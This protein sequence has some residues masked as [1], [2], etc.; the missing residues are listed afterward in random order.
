MNR[1]RF[2]HI[3]RFRHRARPI[4]LMVALL[5]AQYVLIAHQIEHQLR[6]TDAS[7]DICLTAQHLSNT[8]ISKGIP[9]AIVRGQDGITFS[10]VVSPLSSRIITGFSA[11]APPPFLHV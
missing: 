10:S 11:R 1:L 8:P 6:A 4:L 9:P 2:L 3:S 5:F 7:C